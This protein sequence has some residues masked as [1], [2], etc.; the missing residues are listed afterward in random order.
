M[1]AQQALK[2]FRVLQ[3]PMEPQDHKAL[4]VQQVRKE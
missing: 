2:A 4:Q 3:V 1:T